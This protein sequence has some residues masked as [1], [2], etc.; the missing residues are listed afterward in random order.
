MKKKIRN[1]LKLVLLAVFITS[2]A[3]LVSRMFDRADGSDAYENALAIASGGNSSRSEIVETPVPAAAE[4]EKGWVPAPV[5]ED[6]PILEEMA[7]I[8]LAALREVNPD[9]LGWIRIPNTKINYP[10]M[11]GEDN[12][13]YL[14]R[15]WDGKKNSVGSIFLEC[16]NSPDLMDF[17][18]IIYG[19]NMRDDSMFSDLRNYSIKDYWMRNPY[20]YIVTDAG[21]YRYE[22]FSAYKADLES[23]TFG[24]EFATEQSRNSFLRHTLKKSEFVTGDVPGENDRVLTLSTCYGNTS[25]T[26]WVVHARLRM[27]EVSA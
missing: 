4:P 10:L 18:T 16:Q 8:D 22:I 26:R 12:D 3:L 6:D 15:T 20:V 23:I 11:R 1:G 2:T 9:V 5:E 13:Y 27:V 24:L 21:V 14:N 7:Q 17:N 19:H 25:E